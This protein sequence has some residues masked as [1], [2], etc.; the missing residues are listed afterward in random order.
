[1]VHCNLVWG[2]IEIGA[3][4]PTYFKNFKTTPT[5]TAE[6]ET[7]NNVSKIKYMMMCNKLWE[8]LSSSFK[9]ESIDSKEKF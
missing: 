3:N 1:M 5:N 2:L 7:E 4:T 6:L 8:S 9:I